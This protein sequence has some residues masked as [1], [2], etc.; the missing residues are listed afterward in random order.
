MLLH[1][2]SNRMFLKKKKRYFMSKH[3][4]MEKKSIFNK[5][6]SSL[7]ETNNEKSYE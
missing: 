4:N 6:V 2:K 5:Y 7:N 3:E 1:S